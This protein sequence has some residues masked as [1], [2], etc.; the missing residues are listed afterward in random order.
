MKT[1]SRDAI[2]RMTGSGSGGASIGG[3]GGASIDLTGYATE[4]WTDENYGWTRLDRVDIIPVPEGYILD[5]PPCE[6]IR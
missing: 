1:I 3:G 2:Q 6:D 4:M 5:L